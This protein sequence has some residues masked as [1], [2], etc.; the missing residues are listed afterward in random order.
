V[1]PRPHPH[2]PR[3][4]RLLPPRGSSLGTPASPGPAPPGSAAPGAAGSR[5]R[6]RGRASSG[7]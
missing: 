6:G 7:P 5:R 2:R 3:Q 1:Q 4:Q